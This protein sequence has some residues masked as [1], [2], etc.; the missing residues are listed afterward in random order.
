MTTR[1]A[2]RDAGKQKYNHMQEERAAATRELAAV[3]KEKESAT[4]SMFQ[5]LAKQRFG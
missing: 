5:Q 1:L 2:K 4:M 3:Y